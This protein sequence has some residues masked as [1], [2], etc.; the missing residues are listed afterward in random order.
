MRLVIQDCHSCTLLFDYPLRIRKRI[1]T[2]NLRSQHRRKHSNP[3]SVIEIKTKSIF[4]SEHGPKVHKFPFFVDNI[5][6]TPFMIS[7]KT[8]NLEDHLFGFEFPSIP[9][10]YVNSYS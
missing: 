2:E 5:I 9:Y 10:W 7:K 1:K 6:N 4:R 3:I 8:L